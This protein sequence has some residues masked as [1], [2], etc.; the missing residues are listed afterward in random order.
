MVQVRDDGGLQ[1]QMT[2]E[3]WGSDHFGFKARVRRIRVKEREVK[4]GF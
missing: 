4:D 3:V 2:A 1:R